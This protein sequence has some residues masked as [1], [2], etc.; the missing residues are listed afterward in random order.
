MN[1]AIMAV[2]GLVSLCLSTRSCLCVGVEFH[3]PSLHSLLSKEYMKPSFLF[4]GRALLVPRLT[5]IAANRIHAREIKMVNYYHE[6]RDI[7]HQVMTFRSV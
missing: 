5:I 3:A 1:Y 6:S 4:P 2:L 7:A